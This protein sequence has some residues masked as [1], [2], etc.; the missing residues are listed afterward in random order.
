MRRR[1]RVSQSD[2][3][4][5]REDAE[6]Q[7]VCEGA[8]YCAGPVCLTNINSVHEKPRLLWGSVVRFTDVVDW[9]TMKS[10]FSSV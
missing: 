7:N 1:P 10:L 6:V 9:L 8:R 5:I 4:C 3:F 2:T